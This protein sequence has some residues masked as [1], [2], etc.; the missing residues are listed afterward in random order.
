VSLIT[1]ALGL[2]QGRSEK[3]ITRQEK[4][5]PFPKPPGQGR[6]IQAIVLTLVLIALALFCFLR[7]AQVYEWFEELVGIQVSRKTVPETPA[8]SPPAA[9]A[10]QSETLLTTTPQDRASVENGKTAPEQSGRPSGVPVHGAGPAVQP[11]KETLAVTP[12]VA[13]TT[14]PE[15]QLPIPKRDTAPKENDKSIQEHSGRL[16]GVPTNEIAPA[17]EPSKKGKKLPEIGAVETSVDS[18]VLHSVSVESIE[19]IKNTD[20][21]FLEQ[22]R[23]NRVENF[24]LNLRVQGVRIQGLESRIMVDGSLIGVG[25]AIGDFGL[26]LKSVDSGRL[27][28]VDS[29]GQEYPKS[30]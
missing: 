11:D 4:Y 13:F 25:E 6:E 12:P 15:T 3:K 9:F 1:D 5:P 19:K 16:S 29:E 7:G 28:F 17:V 21:K 26:R 27:V 30:Y 24:L 2:R 20:P 14:Q 8:V 22:E 18:G 10:T 23:R